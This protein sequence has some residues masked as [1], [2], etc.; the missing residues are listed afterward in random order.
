MFIRDGFQLSLINTIGTLRHILT[1][2]L[3]LS[4]NNG[5]LMKNALMKIV[6]LDGHTLNPGDLDWRH[7]EALGE[8]IVFDRT[9]PGLVVPRAAG[10]DLVL[11]NKTV[12]GRDEIAALDALRY[13][14]VLATG[15]N[16][17]DIETARSRGVVVANV[18]AYSTRS[19]VQLT[20]ALLLELA[21]RTGHH[22]EAVRSGRWSQSADFC[23][24][25]APLVELDGLTIGLVGF[26]Q[27]GRAVAEV[28]RAFGMRA[29][30]H[31]AHPEKHAA[32]GVEFV[33]LDELFQRSDVVSLHCPLTPQ[34]RHLVNDAR[35]ASMKPSAFLLNTGRGPLVDEGALAAA[36]N[37]GRI[38][39]AGVDVLSVEPPPADNPLLHAKNCIITPHIGWAT[40]AARRRLMRVAVE[41]VQAFL[42]GRPTN[43][44]S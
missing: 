6:V 14:G 29:I 13:I 40:L 43:V 44:V 8:C 4:R 15:Y 34:T 2:K 39:G 22:S 33:G 17:V 5:S 38:A 27:I 32:A 19:V 20:F 12:L 37:G 35:L 25:D 31:T 21:H 30:A 16:V 26:G 11:T 10:A 24:W 42:A 7:L 9:P 3:K 1:A 41:N 36:L 18:P 23:F 28:A